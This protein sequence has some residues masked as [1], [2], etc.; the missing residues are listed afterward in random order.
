M[1]ED[2]M[3][4]EVCSAMECRGKTVT[5]GSVVPLTVLTDAVIAHRARYQIGADRGEGERMVRLA[6]MG[7]G[8]TAEYTEGLRREGLEGIARERAAKDRTGLEPGESRKE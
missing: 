6:R 7:P 1:I 5:G 2:K 3:V 4:K 8:W